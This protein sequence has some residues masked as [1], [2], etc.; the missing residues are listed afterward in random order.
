MLSSAGEE[1]LCP[2]VSEESQKDVVAHNGFLA[3]RVKQ[4]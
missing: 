1:S 2:K 3:E 4:C